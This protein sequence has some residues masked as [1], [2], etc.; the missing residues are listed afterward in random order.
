MKKVKLIL[1]VI[2]L[3]IG[4]N[5]SAQHD[6]KMDFAGFVI[7]QYG[8]LYEN[9][10]SPSMS[11]GG[12]INYHVLELEAGDDDF[13]YSGLNIVP[14]FRFYFNPVDG[15]DGFY[16]GPYL[17]YKR[18]TSNDF[19]Y[20]NSENIFK[21]GERTSTGL[22]FGLGMGKK[23]VSDA[24]FIFETYFGFGRYIME[25]ESYENNEQEDHYENTSIEGLPSVD[26]RFSLSVGWRIN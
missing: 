15:A 12:D 7:G 11:V 23:W 3:A 9:V 24:G 22:A 14:E 17:K 21:E 18:V 13:E 8:I 25:N 5:A 19:G 26:G 2:C 10:L 20:V 4:V 16:V 1:S 6:I